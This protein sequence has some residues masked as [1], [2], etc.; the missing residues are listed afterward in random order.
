MNEVIQYSCPP[1]V[2]MCGRRFLFYAVV[3]IVV[4]ATS[5]CYIFRLPQCP[6]AEPPLFDEPA[7]TLDMGSQEVECG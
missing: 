4:L 2:R 1:R 5:G 7:K 3:L 6:P